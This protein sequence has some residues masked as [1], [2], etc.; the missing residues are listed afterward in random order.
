MHKIWKV[1]LLRPVY[2]ELKDQC[3]SVSRSINLIE[4]LTFFKKKIELVQKCVENPIDQI[5]RK[6]WCW[7]SILIIDA[8]AKRALK[9]FFGW[10]PLVIQRFIQPAWNTIHLSFPQWLASHI[11]LDRFSSFEKAYPCIFLIRTVNEVVLG[12]SFSWCG[13]RSRVLLKVIILLQPWLRKSH[14]MQNT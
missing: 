7:Y 8:W 5:R 10:F 6:G 9:H 2:I 12:M 13:Q 3:C 14:Y 11:T 4:L 1:S